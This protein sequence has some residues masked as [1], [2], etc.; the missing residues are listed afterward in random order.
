MRP[1]PLLR[2]LAVVAAFVPAPE[3]TAQSYSDP[4]LGIGADAGFSEG[5]SADGLSLAAGLHLRYRFTGSL[6]LE[7]RIGYRRETAED[8]SGPLLDIVDIPVTGT[9]QL[10]FFP[11]SRVQ[12]FLL[13]GAGLHVV[14]TTPQG[15]NTTFGGGTEALFAMHAGAGVDVRPSRTTAVHLD[16]RW[17]FL[18]PTAI[19][20][21]VNAGY[22]VRAGYF[23][24]ALGLTFFR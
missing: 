18:E 13:G 16:A 7:G 21:L 12:P 4:G 20:D 19:T 8:G 3:A 24:I 22:D 5:R 11:R 14:R 15:R 6:G 23:A 17:V 1:F 2:V 10:F 9:A